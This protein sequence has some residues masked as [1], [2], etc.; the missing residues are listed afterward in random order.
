MFDQHSIRSIRNDFIASGVIKSKTDFDRL[1]NIVS[2]VEH[3]Y[4]MLVTKGGDQDRLYICIAD[5]PDAVPQLV[6][7][8][9]LD[10]ANDSNISDM[11][12][13]LKEMTFKKGRKTAYDNLQKREL[14]TRLSDY[15]K[16]LSNKFDMSPDDI[17]DEINQV[18][19]ID[20]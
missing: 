8:P 19:D 5:K 6:E 1:Y 11:V 10:V 15:I 3:S 14:K 17:Q 13:R 16:F 4:L 12:E 7:F 18:Y 2:K 20:F 9:H